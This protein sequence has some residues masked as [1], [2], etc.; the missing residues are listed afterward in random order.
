VEATRCAFA[1][2]ILLR[3]R[4][5]G[6]VHSGIIALLV[7]IDTALEEVRAGTENELTKAAFLNL[8]SRANI[9]VFANIDQFVKAKQA[10]KG[11]SAPLTASAAPW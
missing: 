2:D 7:P 4:F 3:N 5:I 8:L 1:V 11:K 6:R 9:E 10:I